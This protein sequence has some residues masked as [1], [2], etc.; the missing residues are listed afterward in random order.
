[1]VSLVGIDEESTGVI[2]VLDKALE[3]SRGKL[4]VHVRQKQCYKAP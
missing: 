2:Y 4:S 1:M 3:E